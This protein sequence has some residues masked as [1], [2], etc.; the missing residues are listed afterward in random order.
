M[1][2][3][4]ILMVKILLLTFIFLTGCNLSAKTN[5]ST[6]KI[7]E[8]D[9]TDQGI[10]AEGGGIELVKQGDSCLL[11]LS[12]YGE[13]GQEKYKFNFKKNNLI[14]TNYLKYRYKNGLIVVDDDLKDLIANDQ[15]KVSDGDM[16]LVINKS[17]IGNENRNIAKKFNTY[18]RKVPQKVLN[19]HCN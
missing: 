3:K 5:L 16:D 8:L 10:S 12:I 11:I 19:D 4:R 6:K 13:V 14:S 9:L 17:F 1:F 2:N 18:K 15:V 7:F